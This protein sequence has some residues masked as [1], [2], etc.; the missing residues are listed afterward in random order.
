LT[1]LRTFFGLVPTGIARSPALR[2]VPGG[3]FRAPPGP[4]CRQ[5]RAAGRALRVPAGWAS[6]PPFPR[7]AAA[8][9]KRVTGSAPRCGRPPSRLALNLVAAGSGISYVDSLTVHH[10]PSLARHSPQE[11]RAG[12]WRSRLLTGVMRLPWA[13]VLRTVGEAVA[14]AARPPRPPGVAAG[15]CRSPCSATCRDSAPAASV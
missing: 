12:I 1:V 5:R 13:D 14:V 4:A 7:R 6:G 9:T 8:G 10:H 2:A 11:R 15:W 3:E